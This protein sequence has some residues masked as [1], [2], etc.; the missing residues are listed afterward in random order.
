[1]ANDYSWGLDAPQ[2]A[3]L[4]HDKL[5]AHYSKNWSKEKQNEYNKW[6]YQ[7]NKEKWDSVNKEKLRTARE[8]KA[9]M[10][11]AT[12]D[13]NNS[14]WMANAYKKNA[15]KYGHEGEH[16]TAYDRR[17]KKID[18]ETYG[19]HVKNLRA[20]QRVHEGIARNAENTKERLSNPKKAGYTSSSNQN[21]KRQVDSI[22]SDR[23]KLSNKVK[24]DVER[25]TKKAKK[26]A[27]ALASSAINKLRNIKL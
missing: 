24:F 27:S 19:E 15:D 6:H 3:Y 17:N 26:T 4:Q 2:D 7:H 9:A 22:K 18:G 1:M 20:G 5:G 14:T 12:E 10:R 16:M 11:Q 8:N 23:D 13:Y 25:T 21:I